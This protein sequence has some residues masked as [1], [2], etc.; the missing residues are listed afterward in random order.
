MSK[1]KY[2]IDQRLRYSLEHANHISLCLKHF[3]ITKKI[4]REF[5]KQNFFISFLKNFFNLPINI[6]YFFKRLKIYGE[7]QW[8]LKEIEIL[9]KEIEE[10]NKK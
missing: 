2:E 6:L 8:T 9:K 5:D 3:E 1:F 7:Y 4:D 10:Y